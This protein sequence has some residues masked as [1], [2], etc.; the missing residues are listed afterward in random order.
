MSL[1]CSHC[2][3]AHDV[4]ALAE[5]SQVSCAC[6]RAFTA[7]AGTIAPVAQAPGE[8]Q[9]VAT[10]VFGAAP[11]HPA[12]T[13]REDRSSVASPAEGAAAASPSGGA[14]AP[15]SPAPAQPAFDATPAPALDPTMVPSKSSPG[16]AVPASEAI[17]RPGGD[18]TLVRS[19]STPR[20]PGLELI[21]LLGRGGMGEVWRARQLSLG[22][23]VA[24]KLLP[25]H[26]ASDPEF[27]ARFDKE[28][29]A[30]AALSHPNIVQI[31]D[32]GREGQHYFFV[33]ELVEGRSLRERLEAGRPSPAETLRLLLQIARALEAA[34][35]GGIIHRDLK[36]ENV[37]LD[38][39][40]H[41]KV[42]DFGLA[43]FNG[44]RS[45]GQQL[46]ASR[47]AMGT[48]NYMAPEQRREARSV[49]G[50]A[51]L[52]SLGVILYELFTGDLPIGR[53][54][55][56]T[57]KVPAADPALDGIAEHLLANDPNER[58]ATA[59]PLI[60]DLEVVL[61]R[62]TATQ[63]GTG[64]EGLSGPGVGLLASQA[65]TTLPERPSPSWRR[66]ATVGALGLMLLGA[67]TWKLWP[68]SAAT[69]SG[70]VAVDSGDE[71]ELLV[72]PGVRQ[73]PPNTNEELQAKLTE[74]ALGKGRV[75]LGIA[76][77]PG[78]E[79]MSAHEGHWRFE[80][81]VLRATQAGTDTAREGGALRP[82]A[83]VSDRYFGADDFTAE[84]TLELSDLSAPY[85]AEPANTRFAELSFRVTGMQ[86]SVL[87][88]PGTGLRLQWK[89]RTPN[90]EEVTGSSQEQIDQLL[91][92]VF[93]VPRGPFLLRLTLK[94]EKGGIQATG[95]V[96]ARDGVRS[97]GTPQRRA[98]PFARAMLPGLEGR[99]AKLALGC[100]NLEC[101]FSELSLEGAPRDPDTDRVTGTTARRSQR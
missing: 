9:P 25:E 42:A 36:P 76:F 31:I 30:L 59:T 73:Y 12:G 90:G 91:A 86:V 58:Y 67:A 17:T 40:G 55:P 68:T 33:M 27:V 72:V 22:R 100:R 53:F 78:E 37:L 62:T 29:T 54:A 89:Y 34:H 1:T 70:L 20:L 2:G 49:D 52:Y 77:E 75:R 51:D 95:W 46:T 57:R 19:P 32:R 44:D 24:V 83:Y 81:G 6:G 87:A 61:G 97:D 65:R 88:I 56:I 85:A 3:R 92:D 43:G 26:L 93:P 10:S 74:Q 71:G 13:P 18:Q 8:R 96:H 82:R 69:P 84:A 15:G 98:Y 5:G 41:A 7:T 23:T 47:V 64:M 39:R 35:E 101:T 21:E 50:R 94:R 80:G 48:L 63:S 4:G 66:G 16:A 38:G 99:V 79:P 45:A 28:S 60:A 11:A 14:M